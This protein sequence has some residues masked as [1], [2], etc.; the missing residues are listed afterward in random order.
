MSHQSSD[1]ECRKCNATVQQWVGWGGKNE[2][3]VA[4]MS[5]QLLCP[6]SV[7]IMRKFGQ[8]A[9]DQEVVVVDEK[10]NWWRQSACQMRSDVQHLDTWRSFGQSL[11]FGLNGQGLHFG[12]AVL[13]TPQLKLLS[14]SC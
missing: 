11:G 1:P 5:P 2:A 4:G 13:R 9:M 12:G 6:E 3:P 7:T 14:S 8:E 10:R